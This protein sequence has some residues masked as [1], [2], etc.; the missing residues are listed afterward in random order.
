MQYT[1]LLACAVPFSKP[2]KN[3]SRNDSISDTPP[4]VRRRHE[5][6]LK[7]TETKDSRKMPVNYSSGFSAEKPHQNSRQQKEGQIRY[8]TRR[9]HDIWSD[10]SSRLHTERPK[11]QEPITLNS[12]TMERESTDILM[13]SMGSKGLTVT[14]LTCLMA[15][16]EKMG[17]PYTGR[18][19]APPPQCGHPI[20]PDC[21]ASPGP[22]QA[23][24]RAHV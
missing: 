5:Q 11:L 2:G 1:S 24:E 9:H 22:A 15:L 17:R 3:F 6:D 10:R 7:A 12:L 18:S 20:R 21:V 13:G 4:D 19:L 16:H 14:N 23:G 8:T